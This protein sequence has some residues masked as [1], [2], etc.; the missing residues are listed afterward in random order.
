MVTDAELRDVLR[1]EKDKADWKRR[2][3]EQKDPNGAVQQK[4]KREQYYVDNLSW[5]S[6]PISLIGKEQGE[7]WWRFAPQAQKYKAGL[8]E[9]E[10]V[11]LV[12]CIAW[13]AFWTGIGF[14]FLLQF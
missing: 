11:F 4:K 10:N 9:L 5:D 14:L 8:I 7:H 1:K 2:R 6:R 12:F 3:K 13:I